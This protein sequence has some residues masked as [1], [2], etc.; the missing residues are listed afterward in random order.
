MADLDTLIQQGDELRGT[1]LGSPRFKIWA[2][3]VREAVQP[4]GESMMKILEGALRRGVISMSHRNYNDEQIDQVNE[5]LRTLKERSPADSRAQDVLINQKQAEA[6]ASL[7][8]KFGSITVNGDATF[9][10]GSPI[11][12]VTVSEFLAGLIDEVEAMPESE[13]KHRIL[14]GLK[15]TLSNP[16]FAAI[17]SSVLSEVVRRLMHS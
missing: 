17:S 1:E 5:L 16:T 3:D 7:Q 15:S 14:D 4:Y 9:G 13:D 10:D 8:H 6:R 12:K 2:N 11:T